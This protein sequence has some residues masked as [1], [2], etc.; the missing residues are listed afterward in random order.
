MFITQ[1]LG[2]PTSGHFNYDF[3]DVRI[4]ADTQL[5]IDPCLL[6]V[7][8]DEWS[9]TASLTMQSYFTTLF[10]RWRSGQS[11]TDL[12][13]HAR[14]ENAAK[15]G[16]GTGYNGKGNTAEGLGKIF[17]DVA[18]RTKAIQTLSKAQDLVVFVNRFDEDG[19][20]DLLTNILH[21]HLNDFT[22]AQLQHC[23]IKPTEKRKFHAWSAKTLRWEEYNAPCFSHEGRKILL[24]PKWIVRKNF[25]FGPEQY[26]RSVIVENIRRENDW[27]DMSKNDVLANMAKRGHDWRYT[28][29]DEYT[30]RHQDILSSYHNMLPVRYR[31]SDAGM[32]DE[33]LDAIIYG[34]SLIH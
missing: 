6:E 32:T 17:A 18:Q 21:K 16:Y 8:S 1:L 31:R 22:V 20:S 24:V 12:L 26:I 25:L 19:M 34:K 4:D 15:F 3:V 33:R 11:A 2:I 28:Y 13:C 7:A 27:E 10:S 29:V 9:R 30:I 5:F 23:G 14:E